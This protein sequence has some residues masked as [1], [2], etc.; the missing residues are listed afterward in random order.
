[1]ADQNSACTE[2]HPGS[3]PNESQRQIPFDAGKNIGGARSATAEESGTVK[4]NPSPTW[5]D[6]VRRRGD[7]ECN[8]DLLPSILTD[9][10][11]KRQG[12]QHDL[13]AALL[14]HT[15]TLPVA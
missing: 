2:K 6:L 4:V 9:P 8:G 11:E 7:F 14:E 3:S 12:S 10:F 5:G 15:Q 13:A 1:M